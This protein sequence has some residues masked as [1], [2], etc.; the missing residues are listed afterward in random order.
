MTVSP[1][2]DHFAI[3]ERLL[4]GVSAHGDDGTSDS[5]ALIAPAFQEELG[6]ALANLRQ[7]MEDG[8]I[9]V[10]EQDRGRLNAIFQRILKLEGMTHARLSWFSDLEA[11]LRNQDK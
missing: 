1:V 6:E 3:I 8:K 4:D 11:N 7:D 2:E 10:T 5:P 9:T